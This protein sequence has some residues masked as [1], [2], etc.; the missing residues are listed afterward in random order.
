M[1]DV[2][3][4]IL[5]FVGVM[6]LVGLIRFLAW[7]TDLKD[8]H[9]SLGRAGVNTIKKYVD[10]RPRV[11]SHETPQTAQTSQT[12]EP[13]R[14]VS[15]DNPLVER[16]RVDKTKTALIELLV[17]SGWDTSQVRS[18]LKGD[19]G[20]LG[21]EVEMAQKRLGITPPAL[22]VTPIVGRPTSA[23]F[24]VTDPEYPYRAPA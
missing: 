24:D 2:G 8:E 1:S 3:I 7:L 17:Y 22:H 12:D 20:A 10:V 23:K 4:G 9:G 21:V 19:N 11:M 14:R 15:V 6:G 16:I 13:D 5:L 18:V